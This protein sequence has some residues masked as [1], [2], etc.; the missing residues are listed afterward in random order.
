[1]ELFAQ[2]GFHP[3]TDLGQNFLI[4]LNL[5]E[6]VV[7]EAHLDRDDVVLE[8][9]CGTGGMTTYLTLEAGA[10][11]SVEVD[12]RMFELAQDA[13]EGC[14]NVTLLNCD[15]LKNKNHFSPLVL[16]TVAEKLAEDPE[17][18]LKL[19]ANLPYSVAT[20]VISN[21]VASDLCWARIVA[22]IQLELAQKMRL[23]RQR[24][25]RCAVG[26]AAVAVSI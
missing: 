19:V 13:V 23:A 7:R 2:H 26:L 18:R 3:R 17:R 25:L 4:D 16:E 10:V 21:L 20:P 24:A 15:V 22:T 9:G 1:M 5:V 11:V 14:S 8:V 12:K 6:Y